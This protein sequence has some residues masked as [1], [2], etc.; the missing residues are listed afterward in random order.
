M[1]V[2]DKGTAKYQD[3]CHTPLIF[4]SSLKTYSGLKTNS[5]TYKRSQGFSFHLGSNSGGISQ[6]G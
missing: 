5:L 1:V 2:R 4:L 6:R 3:A